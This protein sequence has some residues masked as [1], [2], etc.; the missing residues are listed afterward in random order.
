MPHSLE[1]SGTSRHLTRREALV[2]AVTTILG[3]G[4][5]TSPEH[6]PQGILPLPLSEGL[7]GVINWYLMR[8]VGYQAAAS[9]HIVF[10]LFRSARLRRQ[11]RTGKIQW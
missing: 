11:Y 3:L 2:G 4:A 5:A 6:K 8:R 7:E 9:S 10:S 1:P